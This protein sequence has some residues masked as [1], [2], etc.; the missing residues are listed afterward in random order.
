MLKRYVYGTFIAA[1]LLFA[2]PADRAFA[3]DSS[4]TSSTSL[5]YSGGSQVVSGTDPEPTSPDI[6]QAIFTILSLV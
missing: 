5:T 3:S 2:I 4:S 6:I 1:G